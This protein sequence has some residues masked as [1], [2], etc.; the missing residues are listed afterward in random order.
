[1][2]SSPNPEVLAGATRNRLLHALPAEDRFRVLA[3]ASMVRME[4]ARELYRANGRIGTL[5]FPLDSVISILA[6]TDGEPD[7]EVAT[8]GNE[9]LVGAGA[10]AGVP[11]ALGK[12]V[13]Q[14]PGHAITL[15][16]SEAERLVTE[17]PNLAL[18]I[19]RFLFAFVR[20]VAQAS[21]CYR[22]HSVEQ[23][24][25]R[26]LLLSQDR[27]GTD[28]FPLTQEFLASM[29]GASRSSVNLTLGL[30]RKTGAIAHSY[31]TVRVLRR[32]QLEAIACPCYRIIREAFDIV[33]L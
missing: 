28:E 5:Y 2:G 25:A 30:F 13:V 3:N 26:W 17:V 7:T 33:R 24:C 1:M 19:R 20:L 11:R 14:V 29:V 8:V 21:A 22:L 10:T 12:T 9:G 23:R 15:T 32:E 4:P 18:L 27:A 31:R 16:A 6:R